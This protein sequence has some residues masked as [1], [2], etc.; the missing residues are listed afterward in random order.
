M[1][2][3][4]W[5]SDEI[6]LKHK[7]KNP[8]PES[9]KRLLSIS[10][11]VAPIKEKLI[12]VEPE[13]ATVDE[14]LMVHKIDMIKK[15]ELF[16]RVEEPLDMDTYTSY[17]SFEVALMA[18]GAGLRAVDGV[19]DGEFERAFCA[20]RPPGHHATPTK[21]M[22]FCLFNN[23]AIT[24]RYAQKRGFKRVM[25]V[26]FDVH[27]GNGTQDAFYSDSSVF[28]FSSHQAFA[29]PNTG[30]E[31]ERGAG[32]GLGYTAN[33]LLMPNSTDKEILEIYDVDLKRDFEFFKPDIILVSAGYDLHESDPLAQ[34]DITTN[35]IRGVVRRIL[36][37]DSTL[38]IIF[39]L[40]GGYS[41]RDLGLNVLA[42]I[43][44]ML[45]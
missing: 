20:V 7:P 26:D 3:V 42:T 41:I 27:H 5:I 21:S 12:R 32:N 31:S 22:G 11:T 16:S 38:P 37:L 23:I 40:E 35:G 4:A 24:A 45:K 17:D 19:V 43:E 6:Y 29:Y 2:K 33:Y 9:P 15:V 10:T 30:L 39:M 8:H 18:V 44:E 13:V 28:Y 25:I 34:L 36:D 14:L 1:R